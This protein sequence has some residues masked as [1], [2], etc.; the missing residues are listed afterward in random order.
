MSVTPQ[1]DNLDM[2]VHQG[3]RFELDPSSTT[4]SALSSHAGA[5]RFA[6]NWGLALLKDRLD[7][8]QALEVLAMRQGAGAGEARAWAAET[9]GP[10]PW[11][12]YSLRKLWNSSK[13]DVAP[14]W[15]ENSKEAYNSGLD[16]LARALKGYFDSKRGARAGKPMGFPSFKKKGGQPS[17]RFGTG[18]IRVVDDRHVALPRLGVIRTKEH[19]TALLDEVV[20][21]MARVLSATIKEEAGRWFVSF[22]CEVERHDSVAT[23][24]DAIVGVDLGVHHFAALSTGELVENPKPVSH[25]ARRMARLNRE[26]SRRQKGSKRRAKTKAKLSRCHRRVANVRRDTL[27]KL[28]THLATAYGTVVI[29]DLAVKNMTASPK[30]RA[31]PENPGHHLENGHAAKA[32]LNR[33]I[34]DIAPGDLRRQLTYKMGWHGG[35]LVVADRWFPSS[36]KCSSC[37][38]TK[39]TLSLA[40]RTYRCEHCGL[41]LDRDHNA[42]RNLAAYGKKHLVAGS[43][44]ET[45]NGRRGDASCTSDTGAHSPKSPRGRKRQDGSGQP[46]KAVTASSQGEAA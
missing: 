19:T 28:T 31:D 2:L 1:S 7:A 24:P 10:V 25:H 12:L 5:S 14:W 11:T 4:H 44:P 9:A 15:K 38:E 30:P 43:G 8:R 18:V 29:E 6:Y 35:H 34:L 26:L 46:A 3:F 36:K 45:Q 27:H 21:G 42:A 41:V 37:K 13:A 16:A 39:A 40:T 33:S 20:A 22:G 23:Y 32:G 17:C